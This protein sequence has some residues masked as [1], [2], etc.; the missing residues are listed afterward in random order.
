MIDARSMAGPTYT[1]DAIDPSMPGIFLVQTITSAVHIVVNDTAGESAVRRVQPKASSG[2]VG[3]REWLP[4]KY[5]EIRVGDGTS[6]E[7]VC[8]EVY[9]E[10]PACT[11]K[12]RRI[13]RVVQISLYSGCPDLPGA[14]SFGR[15]RGLPI[16][17]REEPS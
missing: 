6:F 11:G 3:D 5:Q 10:A 15:P 8:S 13:P 16:S 12:R 9:G 17:T 14:N 7:F 4:A 2:L 1:F